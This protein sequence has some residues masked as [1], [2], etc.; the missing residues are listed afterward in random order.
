MMRTSLRGR[1]GAV[2]VRCRPSRAAG[3]SRRRRARASDRGPGTPRP[4]RRRRAGPGRGN[5]K[6]AAPGRG[7]APQTASVGKLWEIHAGKRRDYSIAK[8]RDVQSSE[9][10]GDHA[11]LLAR[12]VCALL[13]DREP[14]FDEAEPGEQGDKLAPA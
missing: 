4:C 13:I 1:S 12:T 5:A 2:V 6:R 14:V 3:P 7:S 9:E 11:V 10:F 8:L